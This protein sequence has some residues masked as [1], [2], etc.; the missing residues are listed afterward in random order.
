MIP[1]L[2][3]RLKLFGYI[4]GELLSPYMLSLFILLLT[5]LM[6]QMFRFTDVILI[7]GSDLGSILLLLKSLVISTFPIVIPLA[8]LASILLG[9]GR[10]SQ[11]SELVALSSLGYTKRQLLAPAVILCGLSFIFCYYCVSTLGPKGVETSKVLSSQIASETLA[12]NL[13]PGVFLTLGPMTVYVESLDKKNQQFKNF[14]I[15]DRR[16]KQPAVVF[17]KS[18]EILK[19]DNLGS[20]LKM[21]KGQIHYNP[22]EENHA[23]IDFDEYNFMTSSESRKRSSTSIRAMSNFELQRRL[24]SFTPEFKKSH[25]TYRLELH[26]RL[27]L[28]IVCFVFL[29]LG[30]AFGFNIFQR[31]SRS[32]S[33]GICVFLAMSYWI[34]YFIFESLAGNAK[35]IAYVYIPNILFFILSLLWMKFKN[36]TFSDFF[37]FK[38][39]Q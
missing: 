12:S 33:L 26:K 38:S 7:Y 14:F 16:N 15:L 5:I 39:R 6:V 35:L 8:F 1:F 23:V 3:I 27:Q 28:S 17:S 32:E 18:G 11:D 31:V 30:A 24:K 21:K 13:K 25:F 22:K 29:F 10:M 36:D 20:F 4:F 2:K 9:Y 19:K 37:K 34:L